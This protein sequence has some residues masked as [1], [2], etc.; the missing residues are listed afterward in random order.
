[1]SNEPCGMIYLTRVFVCHVVFRWFSNQIGLKIFEGKI[2]GKFDSS[3]IHPIIYHG[4]ASN[5]LEGER[6]NSGKCQFRW[7]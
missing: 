7:S 5:V 4:I 6:K 2:S 3:D 1:M